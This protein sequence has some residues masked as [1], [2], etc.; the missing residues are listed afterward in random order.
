VGQKGIWVKTA[1]STDVEAFLQEARE[2]TNL[3]LGRWCDKIRA[4][5]SRSFGEAIAYSL[6]APGKRVRPALVMGVYS[7]LGG[8]GDI[9]EIAAAVETVHTYS[10]VHDDLPCMDD[11]EL[12]RGRPTTHVKFGTA[13]AV[14]AG[15][16]MVPLAAQ[17]LGEAVDLMGL[18][19]H[20]GADLERTLFEAAG[21]SGMVGGQVLD[22]EAEGQEIDLD[23]LREIHRKKTGALIEASCMMGAMAA[24]SSAAAVAAVRE[25]GKN[26]GE[27]FQ[28]ADDL[29]DATAT[30]EELGKTAGKDARQFKATFVALLGLDGAR[31]AAETCVKNGL[32]A[33]KEADIQSPLLD[34]LAK[35]I[36]ERRS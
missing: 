33:L 12:R 10:L 20:V 25:Y 6:Q 21:A 2:K 3:V 30:S 31:E 35:F 34:N 27:A 15:I 29:L 24:Q 22:L 18:P 17:M 11:D 26:I 23:H 16:E 32:A 14:H 7:E 4:E 5:R 1:N 8:T 9:A 19:K 28:I 36:V 13:A